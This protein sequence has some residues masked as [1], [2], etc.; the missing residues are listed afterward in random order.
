MTG[1]TGINSISTI[2]ADI[3]GISK[4]KSEKVQNQFNTYNNIFG[5]NDIKYRRQ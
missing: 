5:K 4:K 3:N 1:V 2:N